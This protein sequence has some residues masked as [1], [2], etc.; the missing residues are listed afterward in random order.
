MCLSRLP[1]SRVLQ[2]SEEHELAPE[3][4]SLLLRRSNLT[5]PRGLLYR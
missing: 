3:V 4:L 1:G 2:A 5:T